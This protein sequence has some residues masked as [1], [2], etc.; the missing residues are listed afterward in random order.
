MLGI[1]VERRTRAD[2]NE[3]ETLDDFQ[4]LEISEQRNISKIQI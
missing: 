2:R 4:M 1:F 3:S